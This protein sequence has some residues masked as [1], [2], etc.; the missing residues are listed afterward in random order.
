MVFF[1]FFRHHQ[2]VFRSLY[3]GSPFSAI[4]KVYEIP[5]RTIWRR[6]AEKASSC[7]DCVAG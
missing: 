2:N 1:F 7:L 3:G 6:W 4:K 5:A